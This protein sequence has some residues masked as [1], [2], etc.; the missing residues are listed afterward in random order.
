MSGKGWHGESKRHSEAA[1]GH[2]TRSGIVEP[3]KQAISNAANKSQSSVAELKGSVLSQGKVP[4][5]GEKVFGLV[6]F[7]AKPVE[8]VVVSVNNIDNKGLS[9]TY[10]DFKTETGKTYHSNVSQLFRHKPKKVEKQDQYGK[11]SVWE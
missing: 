9:N 3:Q 6:G 2:H 10:V 11:V 4:K 8:G 5:I 1:K 7:D